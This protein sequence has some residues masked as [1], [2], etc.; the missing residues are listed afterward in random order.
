VCQ[1]IGLRWSG[2]GPSFLDPRDNVC[3]FQ[4]G[5]VKSAERKACFVR[6][7][8]LRSALR[9]DGMKIAWGLVGERGCWN[10]SDFADPSVGGHRA[11][12]SGVYSFDDEGMHGRLTKH[13]KRK[14]EPRRRAQS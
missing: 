1:M 10:Y 13:I 9:R 11:E 3:A 6:C 7:H 2:E 14:L 5:D 12:F 8:D 4:T